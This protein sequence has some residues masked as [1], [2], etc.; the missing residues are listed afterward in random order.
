MTNDKKDREMTGSASMANDWSQD[1]LSCKPNLGLTG[2]PE[3]F[4]MITNEEGSLEVNVNSSSTE[5]DSFQGS[6]N[7]GPPS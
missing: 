7:E 2:Q 5:L 4:N 3:V 1:D 6:N